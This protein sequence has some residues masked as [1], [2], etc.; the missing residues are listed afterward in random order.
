MQIRARARQRGVELPLIISDHVDWPDLTRTIDE[1][2]PAEVWV[3]HGREDAVIR[4]CALQGRAARP[5]HLVGYEDE[6]D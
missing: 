5:L 6:A 3:T 1:V 4:W 2:D